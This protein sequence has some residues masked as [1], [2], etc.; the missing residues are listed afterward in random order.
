ML[1]IDTSKPT[2]YETGRLS[3]RLWDEHSVAEGL[4][5]ANAF[6]EE[7]GADPAAMFEF[8]RGVTDEK[9]WRNLE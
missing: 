2:A 3:V 7:F 4:D 5:V 1:T 6:Q 8:N 9:L